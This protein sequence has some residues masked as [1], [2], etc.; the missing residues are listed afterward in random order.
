MI[1]WNCAI[2][3]TGCVKSS[4]GKHFRKVN[5]WSVISKVKKEFKGKFSGVQAHIA[6]ATIKKYVD[7]FAGLLTHNGIEYIAEI[8]EH[9]EVC[10]IEIPS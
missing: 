4:D 1:S 7:S 8:P 9:F 5:Y 2:E 6:G 3:T 10:D